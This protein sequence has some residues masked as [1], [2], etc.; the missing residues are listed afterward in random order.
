MLEK[1]KEKI[2]K[3]ANKYTDGNFS[4]MLVVACMEYKTKEKK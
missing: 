1:D 4:K 2:Q 3:L